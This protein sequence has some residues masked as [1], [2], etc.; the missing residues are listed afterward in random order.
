[1]TPSDRLERA[2]A[3]AQDLREK[4]DAELNF[5]LAALAE[6]GTRPIEIDDEQLRRLAEVSAASSC[7]VGPGSSSLVG[8]RC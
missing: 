5:A 1:M 8:Q 3:E 7:P 6:L 2:L 4:Q